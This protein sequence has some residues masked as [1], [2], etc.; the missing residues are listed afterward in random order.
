M[1]KSDSQPTQRPPMNVYTAMLLLSFVAI[2]V[3][4]LL[5]SLDLFSRRLPLR[6]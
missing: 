3:G 2:S 1:A 5:L 4:C 6:P